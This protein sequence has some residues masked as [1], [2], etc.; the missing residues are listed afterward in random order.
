MCG[1]VNETIRNVAAECSMLTGKAYKNYEHDEVSKVLHWKHCE[2]IGLFR[3][4]E[5]ILSEGVTSLRFFVT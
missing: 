1:E 3:V 5:L 2:K 4:D